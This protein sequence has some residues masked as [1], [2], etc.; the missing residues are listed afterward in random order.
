MINELGLKE[1]EYIAVLLVEEKPSITKSELFRKVTTFAE[2]PSA[3]SGG[4]G[5]AG[6]RLTAPDGRSFFAVQIHGDLYG[7]QQDIAVGAD[8]N[9][10]CVA[11]L[12]FGK[13][14]VSDGQVFSIDQCTI[15]AD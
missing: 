6:V 7:W 1:D 8:A 12:E 2:P 14:F 13:L 3:K 9:G 10:V 5:E 4:V 15:S 11:K